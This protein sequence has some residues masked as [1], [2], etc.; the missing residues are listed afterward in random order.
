VV[1]NMSR[2]GKLLIKLP[3]G[4]TAKIDGDTVFVA[5]PKGTLSIKL[6]EKAKVKIDDQT[7]GVFVD[8]ENFSNIH[9]L[10][11]S[12]LFNMVKGVTDGWF[13]TL[14]LNGTGYRASTTGSDLSLALGFSHPVDIKAPSGINFEVKENKITIK[15]ADKAMVGE[16]AAKI[17]GL[18]PADPYKLKG[19]KYEGE[20]I[21]KK[22]GKAV[23]AAA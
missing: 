17:R 3:V 4:V 18:K 19:F 1:K 8:D 21:I 7:I 20:I 2:I 15:G 10:T 9:G 6:H 13:K 16:M 12:L 23:K 14:E 5:G 11:R 22:V